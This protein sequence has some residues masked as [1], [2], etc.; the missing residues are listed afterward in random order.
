VNLA[1]ILLGQFARSARQAQARQRSAQRASERARLA[2]DHATWPKQW[3]RAQESAREA[4]QRN[5]AFDYRATAQL[6][7][8]KYV[9]RADPQWA[10]AR[11]YRP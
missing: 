8:E 10:R 1:Y 6:H 9:S 7:F 11:G 3:R 2:S 4:C 5:P